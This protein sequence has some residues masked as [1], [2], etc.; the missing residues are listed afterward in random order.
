[1]RWQIDGQAHHCWPTNRSNQGSLSMLQLQLHLS[2]H[3]M[4]T[5][6]LSYFHKLQ[7]GAPVAG[8]AATINATHRC[9][10]C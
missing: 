3:Y 2:S 6:M 4:V 7:Q 5:G 10:L 8:K 9:L 1:M